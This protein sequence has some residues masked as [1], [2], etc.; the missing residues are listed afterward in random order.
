MALSLKPLIAQLPAL[1]GH[2]SDVRSGADLGPGLY[3]DA[4]DNADEQ[5]ET[6]KFGGYIEFNFKGKKGKVNSHPAAA[7]AAHLAAAALALVGLALAPCAPA[8]TCSSLISRP[9]GARS[10]RQGVQTVPRE[11]RRRH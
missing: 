3:D 7:A 2:I 9:T 1:A 4:D 10:V 11:Q 8:S 6:F 5:D